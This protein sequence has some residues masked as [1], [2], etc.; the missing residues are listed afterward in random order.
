MY[1]YIYIYIYIYIILYLDDFYRVSAT[2]D[3]FFA[4]FPL[5]VGRKIYSKS[6]RGVEKFICSL[7]GGV[8][9]FFRSLGGGS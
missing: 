1:K 3:F 5:G 7:G 6:T 8:R 4:F 9:K 2:G